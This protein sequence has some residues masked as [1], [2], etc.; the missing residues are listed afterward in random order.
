MNTTDISDDLAYKVLA[1]ALNNGTR[2]AFPHKLRKLLG[3]DAAPA[4]AVPEEWRG[5]WRHTNG[6]KYKVLQLANTDSDNQRYPL[7]VIYQGE[8][9]KL[10][11]RRADEW[12]RSMTLVQPAGGMEREQAR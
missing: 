1:L 2:E 6:N 10:W 9:G 5:T 12:H 7:L 8:N 4:P 3:E 11:A